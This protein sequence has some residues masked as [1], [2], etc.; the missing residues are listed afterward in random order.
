M[1][2]KPATEG[3]GLSFD[4]GLLSDILDGLLSMTACNWEELSKG[5]AEMLRAEMG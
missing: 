5:L 4:P 3:T 1:Q 2:S